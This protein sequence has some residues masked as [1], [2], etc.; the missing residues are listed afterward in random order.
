V[1]GAF[2]VLIEIS[3]KHLVSGIYLHPITTIF[4]LLYFAMYV[5]LLQD[6]KL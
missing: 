4:T 1:V 3:N 5:K 2:D 6:T